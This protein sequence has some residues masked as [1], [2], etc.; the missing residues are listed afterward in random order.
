MSLTVDE[1]IDGLTFYVQKR[2]LGIATEMAKEFLNNDSTSPY[3]ESGYAILSVVMSYFEMIEQFE[4]GISSERNSK[5]FFLIGFG[6][7]YRSTKLPN[8]EIEKIYDWVRC[9]MYHNSLTKN[10]SP[11]S[12]FY[13]V[14]F[15]VTSCGIEINPGKVVE[16]L[17]DHFEKWIAKL[18]D[19][20]NVSDRHRFLQ[21]AT[22]WGLDQT[23]PSTTT[24]TTPSPTSPG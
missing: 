3:K 2:Q 20:S 5:P 17:S 16:E 23:P 15:D 9:G 10:K 13:Q 22:Q 1:M 6:K 4:Q 24:Q 14:G 8:S 12:R 11:L 7:V 18:K 19:P 21:I